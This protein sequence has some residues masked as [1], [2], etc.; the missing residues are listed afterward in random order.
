VALVGNDERKR[1]PWAAIGRAV[2]SV[3]NVLEILGK[4]ATEVSTF[5]PDGRG[6]SLDA[7]PK[8]DAYRP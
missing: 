2:V 3:A 8:R 4:S 5:R 7:N 6:I 1:R